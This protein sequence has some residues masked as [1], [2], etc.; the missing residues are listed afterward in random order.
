MISYVLLVVITI[1]L[2][3]MVYSF[4]KFYLPSIRAECSEDIYLVV[5]SYSCNLQGQALTINLTNRGLFNVSG[6]FLRFAA[7][8][9]IVRQQI[10][11]GEE[12]ELKGPGDN[13]PLAPDQ[14]TTQKTY[15]LTNRLEEEVENYVLEIQPAIFAEGNLVPCENAITTQPVVC[16]NLSPT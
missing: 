12:M 2:S 16:A 10:N 14:S 7:E 4:L 5:D 9:R 6:V 11:E 15:S 1:T 8:G 3:A 13:S